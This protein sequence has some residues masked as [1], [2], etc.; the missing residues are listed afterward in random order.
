MLLD[1]KQSNCVIIFIISQNEQNEGTELVQ[2]F[3]VHVGWQGFC[4]CFVSNI[5]DFEI[6]F[7]VLYCCYSIIVKISELD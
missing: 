3:V 5:S 4:V 1:S 2:I 7:D 6:K